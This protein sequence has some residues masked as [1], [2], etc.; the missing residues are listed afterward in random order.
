MTYDF[1]PGLGFDRDETFKTLS[2]TPSSIYPF[3]TSIRPPRES[4]C[5]MDHLTP[6]AS[7]TPYRAVSY[8][9][10]SFFYTWTVLSRYGIHTS[11]KKHPKL[12]LSSQVKVKL[13]LSWTLAP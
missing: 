1:R 7:L 4:V 5:H 6:N 2:P 8:P 10:S 11:T 9:P 3:R 13:V 12:P